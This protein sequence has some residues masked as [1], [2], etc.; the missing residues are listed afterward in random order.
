MQQDATANRLA[1]AIVDM[2]EVQHYLMVLWK[3]ESRS[4]QIKED[5]ITKSIRKAAFVA[6][7]IAYSRPFKKSNSGGNADRSLN[8]SDLTLLSGYPELHHLHNTIIE[9]RDRAVAHA[10]W[11]YHPSELVG[12]EKGLTVR[13]SPRPDY[14]EGIALYEFQR[15]SE[16]VCRQ[17]ME[18]AYTRDMHSAQGR[19]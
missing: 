11:D 12:V 7:I 4:L 10:D 18:L 9:K 14:S 19:D 3:L 8:F 1:R 15:L 16:L 13:S 17:C 5:F 6:S 2:E